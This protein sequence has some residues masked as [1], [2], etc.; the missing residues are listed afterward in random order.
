[1]QFIVTNAL[2]MLMIFIELNDLGYVSLSCC[3]YRELDK[4]NLVASLSPTQ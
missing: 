3:S 2:A 4:N 1:M